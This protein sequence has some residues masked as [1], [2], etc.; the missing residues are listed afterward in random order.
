MSHDP[1]QHLPPTMLS[2]RDLEELRLDNRIR[3]LKERERFL[4]GVCAR[5]H[6]A[7]TGHTAERAQRLALAILKEAR[8]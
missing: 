2:E 5:A 1:N 7:L 3:Q 8:P 4:L 6:S